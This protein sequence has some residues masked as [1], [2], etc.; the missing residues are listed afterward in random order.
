MLHNNDI[1]FIDIVLLAIVLVLALSVSFMPG[2][3]YKQP[4][5][6]TIDERLE[7]YRYLIKDTLFREDKVEVFVGEKYYNLNNEQRLNFA[8]NLSWAYYPR[9]VIVKDVSN[10]FLLMSVSEDRH[11][12]LIYQQDPVEGGQREV[13][14]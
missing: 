9:E 8:Q 12:K 5:A 6:M 7:P 13:V 10:N 1:P 3:A 4:N 2:C 11:I 14:K